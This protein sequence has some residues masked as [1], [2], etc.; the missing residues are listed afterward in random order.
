MLISNKKRL[1]RPDWNY[2]QFG[3]FETHQLLIFGKNWVIIEVTS[4]LLLTNIGKLGRVTILTH[5]FNVFG[6]FSAVSKKKWATFYS[7]HLVTLVA[8]VGAS[9]CGESERPALNYHRKHF[10]IG[11][12]RNSGM[13]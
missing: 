1:V 11:L 12:E 10:N 8:R 9:Q 5:T 6:S 3:H 13:L 4:T 7:T 2:L